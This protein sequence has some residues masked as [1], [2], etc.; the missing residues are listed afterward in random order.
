MPT[1]IF[2]Y[3]WPAVAVLA[4]VAD[5]FVSYVSEKSLRGCVA[6]LEAD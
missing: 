4:M 6:F 2:A 1:V 3:K 5:A